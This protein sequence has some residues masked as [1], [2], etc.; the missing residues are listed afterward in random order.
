MSFICRSFYKKPSPAFGLRRVNI[1][2]ASSSTPSQSA[3]SKDEDDKDANNNSRRKLHNALTF[4]NWDK[5]SFLF[6]EMQVFY[7]IF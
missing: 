1:L 5:S 7:A 3:R 2:V 6:S 4:S